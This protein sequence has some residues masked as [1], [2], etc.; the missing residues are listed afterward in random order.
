[1]VYDGECVDAIFLDFAKA[2]DKVPHL[3]LIKKLASHGIDG[4][5][6]EWISRWLMGADAEGWPGRD[7]VWL[8]VGGEWCAA[9]QGA[10]ISVVFDIHKRP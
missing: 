4:K 2:F 7:G 5:L 8:E 10:W 1:M 9:G 6:L 3:R